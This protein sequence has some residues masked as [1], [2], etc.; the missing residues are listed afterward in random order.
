MAGMSAAQFLEG[1]FGGTLSAEQ[2][3]ESIADLA[4]DDSYTGLAYI[5]GT[6]GLQSVE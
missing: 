5:V 6:T 1:R 4:V 2:V 3:G